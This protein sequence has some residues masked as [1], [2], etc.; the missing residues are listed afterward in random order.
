MQRVQPSKTGDTTAA[1]DPVPGPSRL[2]ARL[3]ALITEACE[4]SADELEQTR[5]VLES[6]LLELDATD[7]SASPTR[8]AGQN[9]ERRDRGQSM[10]EPVPGVFVVDARG[11][12]PEL[13]EARET[14]ERFL[15]TTALERTGGNAAAAGRLIGQSSYQMHWLK[16]VLAGQPPRSS[17]G[18]D[19]A[20]APKRRLSRGD[21]HT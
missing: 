20:S 5:R 3:L 11:E 21:R 15:V 9:R 6:A 1:A 16:R 10:R 19:P 12:L 7:A 4:T 8:L 2:L 17:R 18:P 14:L 13:S